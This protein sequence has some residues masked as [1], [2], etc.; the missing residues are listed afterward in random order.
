VL[1]T[2]QAI[3]DKTAS[4]FCKGLASGQLEH[5][6][7]GKAAKAGLHVSAWIN[8]QELSLQMFD[9]LCIRQQQEQSQ[10]PITPRLGRSVSPKNSLP[11]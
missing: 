11:A 5:T 4:N 6:V 10:G 2:T 7:A 8:K 3:D 1:S 9:I